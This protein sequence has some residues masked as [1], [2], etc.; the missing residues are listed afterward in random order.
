MRAIFPAVLGLALVLSACADRR[1]RGPHETDTDFHPTI[2]LLTKYDANNDG[3]ITRAEME[4]GLKKEFDAADT[5]HD[6]KLDADEVAAVNAQRWNDDKSTASTIVDWNQDGF[7]DFNEFASTARS[8]FADIDRNGD[9]QL[10]PDELQAYKGH[11]K[12][13]GDDSDQDS[14]QQHH[15]HRHGGSGGGE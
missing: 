15:G 8:L 13:T 1:D 6:G 11:K 7:V 9:G 5:N 10:T 4:A 14:S 2:D 3:T 12:P